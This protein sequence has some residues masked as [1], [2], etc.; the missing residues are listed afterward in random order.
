MKNQD[1]IVECLDGIRIL[2]FPLPFEGRGKIGI[3]IEYLW[4]VVCIFT[5]TQMVAISKK[6]D[7]VHIC[8]P[9]DLLFLCVLPT[10]YFRKTKVVFDQHDACP[11]IWELK[12]PQGS[13]ILK[14][15]LF[16]FERQTFRVADRV[17]SPNES[18]K[19]IAIRRGNFHPDRVRVVRS[20][21]SIEFI[22]K[23]PKEVTSCRNV[24]NIAYLGTMGSQ[25]GIDLLLL[26]LKEIQSK[27]PDLKLR[28]DLV[29][30]GPEKSQLILLAQDLGLSQICVFHGRVSDSDLREILSSAD[31]AVNP[32]RPSKFNDISSMNKVIEYMALGVP[33]VQFATIEGERTAEKSALQ[34]EH[35]TF[36]SLA[37]AILKLSEDV[38][39]RLAMQEFGL[40]RFKLLCWE[41]QVGNLVTL[42][43]E[44][45]T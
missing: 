40:H 12:Y 26:A 13:A 45:I 7:A 24:L 36:Q 5:L 3:V 30:D 25:E 27:S 22:N 31:I 4:S 32:D 19:E 17:I 16:Y 41:S 6:I 44:L 35:S 11:E 15:A 21:P 37:M 10:K 28:L 8:N 1:K 9:P 29:G 42:Y 14:Q 23:N 38:D 18:Y 33:I 2:R 39:A 43:E 34:A 20:S